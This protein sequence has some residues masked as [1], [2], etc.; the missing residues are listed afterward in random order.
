MNTVS[1][2]FRASGSKTSALST[3]SARRAR[4]DSAPALAHRSVGGRRTQPVSHLAPETLDRLW[5]TRGLTSR[6]AARLVDQAASTE[7][8]LAIS[9]GEVGRGN[10]RRLHVET[11]GLCA[12][13]VTTVVAFAWL[14]MS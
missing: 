12:T 3:T 4:P 2:S 10:L 7:D 11:A 1:S 9:V 8:S 14:M 13:L 6:Q 5:A